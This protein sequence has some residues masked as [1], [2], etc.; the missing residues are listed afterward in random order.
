MINDI[1][2]SINAGFTK[3]AGEFS[4]TKTERTKKKIV[5][6]DDLKK[7]QIIPKTG[8]TGGKI[9]NNYDKHSFQNTEYNAK[10]QITKYNNSGQNLDVKA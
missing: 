9:I 2:D 4:G 8:E 5:N 3:V 6:L 1:V 10:G 7:V